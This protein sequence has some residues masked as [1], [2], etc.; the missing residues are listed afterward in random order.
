MSKIFSQQIVKEAY[1]FFKGI[2]LIEPKKFVYKF[3]EQI[4]SQQIVKEAYQK[5]Q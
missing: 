4:F 3:Y 1:Q 2:S 5:D